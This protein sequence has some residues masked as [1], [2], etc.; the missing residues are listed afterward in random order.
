M[1]RGLDW[2][3]IAV[4]SGRVGL[5]QKAAQRGACVCLGNSPWWG[6]R[7]PWCPRTHRV[8]SREPRAYRQT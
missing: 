8:Y 7:R 5:P 6:D 4:G 3:P 2:G 1:E